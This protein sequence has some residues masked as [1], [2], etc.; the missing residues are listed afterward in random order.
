MRK[1][2]IL[3]I[4]IYHFFAILLVFALGGCGNNQEIQIN[5]S[6]IETEVEGKNNNDI[7]EIM[8]VNQKEDKSI[9]LNY[10][11]IKDLPQKYTKDMAL[12]DGVVINEGKSILN[13]EYLYKFCDLCCDGEDA[14]VRIR[15]SSDEGDPVIID[16]VYK[17]G[18]FTMTVDFS[19]DR[20]TA[21]DDSWVVEKYKYLVAD[22]GLLYLC[23][24][25]ET[26][27]RR[28]FAGIDNKDV[29][30]GHLDKFMN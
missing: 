24:K 28:L 23:K 15:S 16:V 19:R 26:N 18:I 22:D 27:N 9:E 6:K 20:Y 14:M 29:W 8:G 2:C 12:D 17:Q 3:Y 25:Q 11:N 21:A 1:W 4:R 10:V 5:V 30:K 7:Q 13:A